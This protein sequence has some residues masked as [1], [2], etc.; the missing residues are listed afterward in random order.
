MT[1]NTPE[2]GTSTRGGTSSMSSRFEN[3]TVTYSESGVVIPS[4]YPGG[5]TF[6]EAQVAHPLAKVE[7][8]EASRE[9]G[10]MRG[11]HAALEGRLGQDVELPTSASGKDW[12]R[13]SVGV[14]EVGEVT[15]CRPRSSKSRPE[16]SRGSARVQ[17][18]T[19]RGAYPRTPGQVATVWSA[20]GSP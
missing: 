6:A 8:V 7:A 12:T 16:P 15:W 4:F 3:F 2:G 11:I 18:S 1:D 5:V 17:R 13:L 10:R 19:S 20:P 14:G 9:R